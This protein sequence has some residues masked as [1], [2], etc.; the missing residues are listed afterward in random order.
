VT[1]STTLGAAVAVVVGTA[2]PVWPPFAGICPEL[3]SLDMLVCC[4]ASPTSLRPRYTPDFLAWIVK[5]APTRQLAKSVRLKATR[6]QL[7]TSLTYQRSL[8]QPR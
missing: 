8:K 4:C 2:A 3:A 1:L 5:R 6:P 7:Q